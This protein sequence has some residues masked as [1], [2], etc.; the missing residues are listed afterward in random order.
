MKK[1][2]YKCI[3][4]LGIVVMISFS[5]CGTWNMGSKVKQ[6]E[7][8]M[9]KKEVVRVLGNGYTALGGIA[10]PDGNLETIRYTDPI[11]G[12]YVVRFLDGKLVEWFIDENPVPPTPPMPID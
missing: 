6:L 4:A 11:A 1:S 12:W 5:S 7:M 9:T 10:T 8:G 3:L 2:I